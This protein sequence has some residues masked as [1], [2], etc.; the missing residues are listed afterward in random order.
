LTRYSASTSLPALSHA[1]NALG[2]RALSEGFPR[3]SRAVPL[4]ATCPPCRFHVSVA[5]D[6][7]VRGSEGVRKMTDPLLADDGVIRHP[8]PDPLLALI[9]YE[10]L[11]SSTSAWCFHRASSHG[12]RRSRL[13]VANHPSTTTSALQSFREPTRRPNHWGQVSLHGVCAGPPIRPASRSSTA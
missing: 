10:V 13:R 1:G 3:H 9:P 4:G 2:L 12:L 6:A 7:S 5:G 8:E 11:V